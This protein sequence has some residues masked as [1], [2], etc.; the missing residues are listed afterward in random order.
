MNEFGTPMNEAELSMQ[1]KPGRAFVQEQLATSGMEMNVLPAWFA[2]LIIGSTAVSVAGSIIGGSKSA[3]AARRQAELSKEAAER[4][5]QYDQELWVMNQEKI[6]ADRQFAIDNIYAQARNEGKIAQYKDAVNLKQYNYDM[7]IRNREQR[8]LNQQF[9]RSDD[10]YG[11]QITLNAASAKSG[12]EDEFRKFQEIDA[13]ARFNKQEQIL[14]QVKT[15]GKLRARGVNGRSITKASQAS[16]ADLGRQ[17]SMLNESMASAGRNTKAVL[18]AIA[19]DKYSADLSAYAQKMLDPGVL[20]TPIVPFA[21]PMA[22]YLMP[23]QLG[24]WDWGPKPVLGGYMSPSAAAQ[25]V[26]GATISSVAGSIGG[27]MKSYATG[28]AAYQ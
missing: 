10:I 28:H 21:T 8:S 19:R 15:E 25:Q 20:P 3:A 16:L 7:M 1:P 26:W 9:L 24:E 27:G 4:Q 2:P 14:E 23:R 12:K 13:E 18:K 17:M 11:K 6:I 22:E 5:L